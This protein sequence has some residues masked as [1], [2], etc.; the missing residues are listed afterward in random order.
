MREQGHEYSHPVPFLVSGCGHEHRRFCQAES[1][2]PGWD[3]TN[4][5]TNILLLEVSTGEVVKARSVKQR[6]E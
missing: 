1:G 5:P 4:R 6:P 2:K 3:E